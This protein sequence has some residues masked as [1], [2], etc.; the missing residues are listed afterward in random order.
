LPN[1]NGQRIEFSDFRDVLLIQDIDDLQDQ[2]DGK[3]PAV[4]THL[5]AQITDFLH[6]HLMSEVTD[7]DLALGAKADS[8]HEHAMDDIVGLLAALEATPEKFTDLSDV[9]LS[10][11]GQSGLSLRVNNAE[12]GLEFFDPAGADAVPPGVVAMYLANPFASESGSGLGLPSR[13][14]ICDG[15]ELSRTEEAGLFAVIGTMYGSGDGSTTY[16]KPN[17]KGLF[18]RGFDDGEGQDPDASSRLARPDG[19]GGD[20]VGTRQGWEVGVHSHDSSLEIVTDINPTV[21]TIAP[22]G[23]GTEIQVLVPPLDFNAEIVSN[24]NDG[25][26]ESRPV[27]MSVIFIIKL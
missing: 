26:N 1:E 3:S 12:T 8:I 23:G 16:N 21:E 20:R 18:V 11:S 17:M 13:W 22:I 9:P 15:G 27:N 7:L 25:G 4:H 2:L 14:D 19:H 10:Y 6:N 24:T 5:K